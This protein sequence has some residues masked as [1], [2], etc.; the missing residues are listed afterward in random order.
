MGMFASPAPPARKPAPAAAGPEPFRVRPAR[1]GH[2]QAADR[3][4]QAALA[5]PARATGALRPAGAAAGLLRGPLGAGVP[6]PE[7]TRGY[8]EQRLG[9]DLGG[10]RIHAGAAAAASARRIGAAAYTLGSD[11]AFGAGRWQPD[12][13]AGQRLL[14]HELAHVVQQ[15]GGA[16]SLGLGAAPLGVQRALETLG[17]DWET[18][19]YQLVFDASGTVHEGCTIDRLR[20]VPKDPVDATKIGLVQSVTS[21]NNGTVVSPS[22]TVTARSIPAGEPQEGLHIDRLSSRR[23]PVYGMD[24]PAAA[25]GGLGDSAAGGNAQWGHHYRLSLLGLDIPMHRAA[26]LKDTPRIPGHGP[27]ASQIFETTALAVE[28]A[29]AGT[30]YGSVRWGWQSDASNTPSLLPLSVVTVGVPT[31]GFRLASELWNANP[32]STGASTLELPIAAGTAGSRLPREM[33][34]GEIY[35]RLSQIRQER[36]SAVV[37]NMLATIGFG[38]NRTTESL[39][40]EE[41]ALRR[42]LLNRVGDFPLPSGDTRYA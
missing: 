35:A 18:G 42:E 31:A 6:L 41:A 11:I 38:E 22:A 21:L 29:Q 13:A 25:N 16:P 27:N 10:V 9:Q 1:D 12:T 19:T 33:T 5:G 36:E 37:G 4:A 34:T 20:F 8:F 14:A 40:F 32:T 30:F 17:G 7:R 24:D 28:G 39:D 26:E 3:A 15:G 23:N 2:E